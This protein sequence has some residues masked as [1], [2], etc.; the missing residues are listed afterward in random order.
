M[1]DLIDCYSSLQQL[2]NSTQRVS[3]VPV[4]TRTTYPIDI[5]RHSFWSHPIHH[6]I[7]GTLM[8]GFI[9]FLILG[10]CV[11]MLFR[12]PIQSMSFVIKIGFLLIL[13]F[14]TFSALFGGFLYSVSV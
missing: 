13:G 10:W 14:G 2:C 3:T 4:M 1:I 5:I 9:A 8:E 12:H 6:E 7:R 11:W